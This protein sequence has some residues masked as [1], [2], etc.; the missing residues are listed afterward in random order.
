MDVGSLDD[1]RTPTP[2]KNR[3]FLKLLAVFLI[4]IAAT[5]VTLDVMIGNAWENFVRSE[6][7]RDLTQKTLLFAHRVETDHAHS[8]ADIAREEGQ[9]AGARATIIDI[10]RQSA[11]RL[12]GDSR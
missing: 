11:C 7:E 9:A 10:K 4:V 5:A 1:P 12:R 3:I 2:V 8:L 6:I